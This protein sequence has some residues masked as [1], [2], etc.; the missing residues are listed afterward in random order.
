M[1]ASAN[2]PP[3]I[4][5]HANGT[6]RDRDVAWACELAGGAPEIVHVNQLRAGER[7]LDDY[8]MLVLPG[9]F[10]Y[11]DDL[12][13]GALWATMLRHGLAEA[14]QGFVASGRPIIGICNGFQTLVKAGLLPGVSGATPGIGPRTTTLTRNLGGHFECRWVHLAPEVNSPCVFTEGLTEP[15]FCPVAHGEG[16]FLTE[17]EDT[18][19]ALE[20]GGQVALRYVDVNNAGPAGYPANP[21]GSVGDVAGICNP[22]GTV[23]GLMPHPE[24]H[25]RPEQAPHGALGGLGLTLFERGVRYSASC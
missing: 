14:L 18:F 2:T 15:I 3:I 17:S 9:G 6:N 20:A 7:R 8:R 21:N 16:R 10:S 1:P 4:I 25:I 12:G 5:L 13:A 19:A 11:G 23:L 24:D 22:Q